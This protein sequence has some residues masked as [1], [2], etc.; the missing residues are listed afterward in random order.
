MP[1]VDVDIPDHEGAHLRVIGVVLVDVGHSGGQ[2][3]RTRRRLF[4]NE[5]NFFSDLS[6]CPSTLGSG[7]T[8]RILLLVSFNEVM[9]K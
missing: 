2:R 1:Q 9:T 5:M 7:L 6:V 3:F 4:Y 8:Q